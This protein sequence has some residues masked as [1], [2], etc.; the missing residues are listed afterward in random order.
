MIVERPVVGRSRAALWALRIAMVTTLAWAGLTPDRA[1]GQ[2]FSSEHHRFELVTLAE[3]L[4]HP[5]GLAFLP[6]GAILITERPG[7][8]RVLRDGR[9]Q[10]EPLAGIP[11]V[12]ARGQGGLLDVALHPDFAGNRLVYFSYAGEGERGIGTEVARARLVDGALIDLETIFVVRPKS[13]GGRHFGSRLLFGPDGML[14]VTTGERGSPDR[15]QDLRDLAGKV[16]RIADDGAV[17]QDNPFLGRDDVSPE[18]YSSGH[19]NPQGLTLHR[20]S[21]RIWAVE[22]GPKGGDELNVIGPGK[23]YGWPVIT[24][25][26]SYAGFKIGEGTAKP[27]MEQP[28]RFWVPSISPS[29]MAFYWGDDFPA[30]RGN[31]FIGALSGQ[32]LVRLE[33]EGGAV[34]GE[35]R[36][37]SGF[38]KRIRDVRQGPDG[39]LY[40][41]TDSS[42]GALMRLDPLP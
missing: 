10:P 29:G 34:V 8:L 32:A 24:Y 18:I 40:L 36:L 19:R 35:E 5:W 21:G 25:G 12:A 22:H 7:R 6:D 39:R 31:L 37:L 16:L 30:W 4:V 41:L 13:S 42:R 11:T 33:W 3:G 15:A 27:G 2:T 17:P 14:Y 23:N 9:L 20:E 38:G 28:V 1:A 26:R